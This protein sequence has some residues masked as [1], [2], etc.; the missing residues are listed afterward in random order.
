MELPMKKILTTFTLAL[1]VTACAQTDAS[2]SSGMMQDD[3][4]KNCQ[5][6]M[7]DGKCNAH[8]PAPAARR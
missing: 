5:Q 4:M 2:Q 1:L 8:A 6:M 7:K 3:M